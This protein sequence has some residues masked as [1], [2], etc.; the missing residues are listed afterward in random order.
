[1]QSL[2]ALENGYQTRVLLNSADETLCVLIRE[3]R[4]SEDKSRVSLHGFESNRKW[5]THLLE[6]F[7]EGK[8][9]DMPDFPMKNTLL[10]L[11]S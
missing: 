7:V 4:V 6:D 5:L 2:E 11:L 3:I 9:F 10:R 1:M 8:E